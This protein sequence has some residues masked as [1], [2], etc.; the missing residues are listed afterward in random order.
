M[1]IAV[2]ALL[3]LCIIAAYMHLAVA[4]PNVSLM[5]VLRPLRLVSK[6]QDFLNREE[7]QIITF[8]LLTILAITLYIIAHFQYNLW[9]KTYVLIW[10]NP[11]LVGAIY[12]YG[13]AV[14]MSIFHPLLRG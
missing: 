3:S 4:I 12:L 8:K 13:L 11:L 9:E 2:Q 10:L 7:I 14:Q 6:L 1:D 5:F